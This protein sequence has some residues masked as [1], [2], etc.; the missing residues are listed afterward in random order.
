MTPMTSELNASLVPSH[1][2]IPVAEA[3]YRAPRSTTITLHIIC[4]FSGTPRRWLTFDQTF[5]NGNA[6]SRANDHI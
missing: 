4:A 6:L 5:E 2:V 3:T 1:E